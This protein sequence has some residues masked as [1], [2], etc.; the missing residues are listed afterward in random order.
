MA[1]MDSEQGLRVLYDGL[2]YRTQAAG[3]INHY[4]ANLIG[5]LP[6]T[7]VPSLVVARAREINYPSHPN[8][9]VFRQKVFGHYIITRSIERLHFNLTTDFNRQRFDVV[10]PTYYFLLAR[11]SF[12]DFR[13]PVVVT[14][15]DMIHELFPRVD[16]LGAHAR[17]K[18][19]ALMAAR[20]IICV[21][22]NTKKDL[23]ERY[24]SLENKVT[25]THLAAEMDASESYGPEPVPAR[26]YF[27]YVG[28]RPSYK[29]FGGLLTAFA[30]ALSARSCVSLCVVGKPFD[31]AERK[32]IAELK[33]ADRIE[34][35]GFVSD[36]HLAKLYRCGV[37]FV[38]P[39]LYEGFGIPP[40][41]AMACG[42]A[43][44]ASNRSSIPE[45]VGD[46]GLLFDPESNG[47]MAEM[48]ISL[49]D[50]PTA[51]ERLIARGVERAKMFNWEKTVARTVEVYRSV[52]IGI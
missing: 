22:E 4:T 18:R 8:L 15:H 34:H 33:L 28:S 48:M 20:A 11:R 21:S 36:R 44:I 51:R 16:F 37:A 32:R 12:A 52:S 27:L 5:K 23:L 1:V 7:F 42:A 46:A 43:V 13:C 30:K 19:K 40:L 3:G 35:Y 29:N 39:S 10:H 9:R 31:R 50:D 2:I 14:V 25:V 41:E 24:P 45:V 47:E 17:E 49:F 38:Y 26:P 6:D